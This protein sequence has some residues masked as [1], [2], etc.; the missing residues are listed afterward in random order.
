MTF[1]RLNDLFILQLVSPVNSCFS[2]FSSTSNWLLLLPKSSYLLCSS[3]NSSARFLFMSRAW[4]REILS[5]SLSFTKF[6]LSNVVE[7][8]GENRNNTKCM[9]ITWNHFD[10][11][12]WRYPVPFCF[13]IKTKKKKKGSFSCHCRLILAHGG[14]WD[15]TFKS[16][17][18]YSNLS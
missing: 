11:K 9:L 18:H 6:C 10:L 5:W 13:E 2:F 14:G 7:I 3:C 16:N 12:L 8:S 1:L 15:C 17:N 4:S